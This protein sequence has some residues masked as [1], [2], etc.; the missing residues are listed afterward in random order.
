VVAHTSAVVT[1]L[2]EPRVSNRRWLLVGLAV[3]VV[4]AASGYWFERRSP[5]PHGEPDPGGR[6]LAAIR[7][8]AA[9]MLPDDASEVRAMQHE[10]HWDPETCDGKAPGWS[11]GDIDMT[12]H[13]P[14]SVLVSLDLLMR[15]LQWVQDSD[16]GSSSGPAPAS[17]G[18]GFRVYVPSGR[19]PYGET[20]SLTPP[21][22]YGDG[23]WDL[24]VSATPAEVPSHDC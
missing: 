20:A 23:L 4:L 19:N 21:S 16:H 2:R 5:G 10:F 9:R 1:G 7:D 17:P 22:T 14:N 18:P 6:R 11:G 3:V 15:R 13:A 12:F 24:D 8:I